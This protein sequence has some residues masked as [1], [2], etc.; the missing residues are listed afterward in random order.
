MQKCI[1]QS[2]WQV[3]SQ[4]AEVHLLSKVHMFSL[5]AA[6]CPGVLGSARI[7]AFPCAQ[8][9]GFHPFALTPRTGGQTQHFCSTLSGPARL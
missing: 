4:A 1:L 8:A 3:A 5:H 9:S 7:M 2:N 6:R